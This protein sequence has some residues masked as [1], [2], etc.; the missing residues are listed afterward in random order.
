MK[1][2]FTLLLLVV[3]LTAQ[4]QLIE[5]LPTNEKIPTFTTDQIT[6][7][8]GTFAAGS[9]VRSAVEEWTDSKALGVVA[10]TLVGAGIGYAKDRW[11]MKNNNAIPNPY[12]PYNDTLAGGVGGFAGSFTLRINLFNKHNSKAGYNHRYKS[13]RFKRRKH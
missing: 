12:A 4:A 1:K 7:F 13:R 8:A 11:D 5:I 6:T 9:L 10:G 2:L 3:G